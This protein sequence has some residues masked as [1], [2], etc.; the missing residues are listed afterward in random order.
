MK[1]R[2]L[3]I[4][5]PLFNEESRV[6]KAVGELEKYLSVQDFSTQVIFVDDGSTDKTVRKIK[7]LK[8]KFDFEITS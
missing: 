3:S 7:E 4:I 5:I 8:P 6:E 2:F 1:N